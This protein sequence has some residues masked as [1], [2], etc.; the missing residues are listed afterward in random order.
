MRLHSLSSIAASLLLVGCVG[1]YTSGEGGGGGGG[2]G[3]GDGATALELYSALNDQQIAECGACHVGANLDDTTTGP[4]YLGTDKGSSYETILAYKSWV[5]GSPIVGNSPENSKLLLHGV[6]AGP[7]LSDALRT[8]MS[9]WIV[10]QAEEDGVTPDDDEDDID[11]PDPEE[12]PTAEPP[13]TLVEAL[14]LFSNCMTYA[15]FEATNFENVADQNTAEG[16]CYGCHSAGTGGSF[17]SANNIDFYSM[18]RQMPY[19]LKFVTGT[20][21]ADGSFSDLIISG[22]Y[23][24]KRD[25][26]GHPNY[27]MAEE[28]LQS[29]QSFFDL[30]YAKYSNAIQTGIAC[31]PDTPVEQ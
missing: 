13:D 10:K 8:Q 29:I 7:A 2:G 22:R 31:T 14:T 19:I 6:H 12:P 17:L 27:I 5:D 21:N 26:N 20:V 4:D 28:R 9:E 3:G 11:P 23:E 15:D 25:D 1:E 24:M 18:Q 30:T 16:Q